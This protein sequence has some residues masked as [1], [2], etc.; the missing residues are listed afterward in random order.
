MSSLF[1]PAAMARISNPEQLDRVLQVVRPLHVLGLSAIALVLLAGFIWSVLST[2]PVK[3]QG[4]GIL[5][6]AED[7]SKRG[8]VHAIVFVSNNDGK[9]VKEGMSAQVMPSTAKPQKDGFIRGTVIKAAKIPSGREDMMYRLKNATLV[10]DLL[11]TGA[12]FEM[13]VALEADPQAPNGYRWS[14]GAG[15]EISVDAGTPAQV[16]LMVGQQRI[17]SLVLPAFD[18]VFRWLGVD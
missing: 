18:H 11:R 17:I 10:D 16:K 7:A 9:K 2:A 12:P 13:E 6:A 14:S 15:P 4:Q 8:G 5:L 3:V 1:R